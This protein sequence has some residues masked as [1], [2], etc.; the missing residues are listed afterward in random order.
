MEKSKNI[1]A[2]ITNLPDEVIGYYGSGSNSL[3][4]FSVP[5]TFL[6]GISCQMLS[7]GGIPFV[8]WA[9]FAWY[10]VFS[11][12]IYFIINNNGIATQS[13]FGFSKWVYHWSEIAAFH[14]T[15]KVV[16]VRRGSGVENKIVFQKKEGGRDLTLYLY[17]ME[18][19][20]DEIR[21]KVER[22][23]AEQKITIGGIVQL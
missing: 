22:L 15:V 10:K 7:Y 16:Y 19:R 23:T 8:A 20:F 17:G 14:F 18:E 4:F 12:T 5:L 13:P 1:K 21:R 2:F 11:R 9:L 6:A 3:L